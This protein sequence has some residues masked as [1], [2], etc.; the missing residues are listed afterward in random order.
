MA[1]HDRLAARPQP[2][3]VAIVGA[4]RVGRG[5]AHQVRITPG[6]RL[7]V[8]ADMLRDRAQECAESLNMPYRL[9][10]TPE[11]QALAIRCGQVAVSEDGE[12]AAGSGLADVLIETTGAA[13]AGARHGASALDSG[14]HVAMVNLAADLAFGPWLLERARRAGRVYTCACA[15]RAATA[16]DLAHDLDLRGVPVLAA[17]FSVAHLEPFTAPQDGLSAVEV[18]E[19]DGTAVAAELAVLA[20]AIG[21]TVGLPEWPAT[22][23]QD[24]AAL[25]A[26]LSSA[27]S[28]RLLVGRI[29][30]T[31]GHA[32]ALPGA[33]AGGATPITR[34]CHTGPQD[35]LDC[36][37]AAALDGIARLAPWA[38]H[39]ATVIAHAKRD[40]QAGERID[41]PGGW[42]TYG[43]AEPASRNVP[44]ALDEGLP[45][46][47]SDGLTL[48]RPLARG[49]RLR[50]ADCL[51]SEKDPRFAL[52]RKAQQEARKCLG[53]RIPP[54][55]AAE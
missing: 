45:M 42:A 49:T 51:Y 40:L 29:G 27:H 38:G 41:G 22:P 7:V 50:L 10:D 30:G 6:L 46:M 23:P 36:V 4:G 44:Y 33:E 12:M 8:L 11:A 19:A 26:Q 15:N 47:L 39:Q 52:W 21:G 1:W 48:R 32:F 34:P 53:G 18:A 13:F 3:R 24:E 37:A 17:G 28:G 54:V 20:N 35:A 2:I 55:V 16:M 14:A 5:L 25:A 43:V 9:V 31:G